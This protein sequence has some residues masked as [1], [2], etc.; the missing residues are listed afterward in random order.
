MS[1]KTTT[2]ETYSP[3]ELTDLF[4]DLS[5]AAMRTG[6]LNDKEDVVTY[7]LADENLPDG[8]NLES[9]VFEPSND[10][11]IPHQLE[12]LTHQNGIDRHL[13]LTLPR[14]EGEDASGTARMQPFSAD[15]S[16]KEKP[17][18]AK[19]RALLRSLREEFFRAS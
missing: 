13:S 18:T 6:K 12:I 15:C 8:Y 2:A 19:D 17:L 11:T 5:L 14:I 10:D 3:Q 16:D 9:I 1:E 4:M 7:T